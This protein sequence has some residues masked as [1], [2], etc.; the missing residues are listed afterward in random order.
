VISAASA[1]LVHDEDAGSIRLALGAVAPTVVRARRAE[2][3][4][5]ARIDLTGHVQV[6]PQLAAEF[7]GQAAEECSPI[8][9]HRS[10]ASYRRRA[11]A[12]LAERLLLRVNEQRPGSAR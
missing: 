4:L 8:D 6:T 3:W 9:D 2:A 11:I 12:V 5:G 1:C 7:G 10:T